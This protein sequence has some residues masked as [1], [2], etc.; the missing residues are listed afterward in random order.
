MELKVL[1]HLDVART[2][3]YHFGAIIVTGMGFLTDSYNVSFL[4]ISRRTMEVQNPA[5]WVFPYVDVDNH[6][7]SCTQYIL[8]S[9]NAQTGV[10]MHI[11]IVRADLFPARL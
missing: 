5:S 7:G 6:H 11:F 8:A 4:P 3:L 2:Q 1:S 10:S 9:S